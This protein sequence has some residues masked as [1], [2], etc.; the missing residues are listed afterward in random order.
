MFIQDSP[1]LG[2]RRS[3][4]AN[5]AQVYPDAL[6]IPAESQETEL[7]QRRA[8]QG[9]QVANCAVIFAHGYLGSR[10]EPR[11]LTTKV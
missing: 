6:P 8:E 5:Q 3:C 1:S 4:Q 10:F 11:V 9:L 2:L 7:Q